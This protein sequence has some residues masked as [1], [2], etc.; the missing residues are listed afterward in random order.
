MKIEMP[1][2]RD[3]LAVQLNFVHIAKRLGEEQD[4][5]A[6]MRP[7]RPLAKM[8]EAGDMCWQMIGRIPA[9]STRELSKS[10]DAAQHNRQPDNNGHSTF[11]PVRTIA[12]RDLPLF[13]DRINQLDF[14]NFRHKSIVSVL[15]ESGMQCSFVTHHAVKGMNTGKAVAP[16]MPLRS[17]ENF[18]PDQHCHAGQP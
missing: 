16:A 1:D 7:V 15:E 6:V 8:G 9:C 4:A 3:N 18:I 12:H 13:A 11:D 17:S 2:R 14:T 10:A 5:V